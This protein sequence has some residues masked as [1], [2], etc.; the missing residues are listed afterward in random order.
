M[1]P[2]PVSATLSAASPA[3]VGHLT[4]RRGKVLASAGD[5]FWVIFLIGATAPTQL[6]PF[7]SPSR[8]FWLAAYLSVFAMAVGK[9]AKLLAEVRRNWL[10][11]TWPLIASASAL[12]SLAPAVSLYHGVQLAMT[13]LIGLYLQSIKGLA[14]VLRLLFIALLISLLASFALLVI[15]PVSANGWTKE[16]RGIYHHKNEMGLHTLVLLTT[17]FCLFLDGW[18]RTLTLAGGVLALAALAMTKSGAAL[19]T[20][21]VVLTILPLALCH[22]LGRDFLKLGLGLLLLTA[23][24]FA[25]L[26]ITLSL[27]PFDLALGSVGKDPTLTGRTILWQFAWDAIG[28]S[29]LLGLGFKGYWEGTGTTVL[30]LRYVIGQDLWFFHNCFLEVA[31]AFGIFGLLLFVGTLSISAY[32]AASRFYTERSGTTLWSMIMMVVLIIYCFVENPLFWNHSLL[33]LLFAIIWAASLPTRVPLPS[34]RH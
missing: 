3:F 17:A 5:A 32:R 18:K 1:P 24:F 13:M 6:L 23:A 29:P 28:S 8:P 31:V 21:A 2:S 26:L 4:G 30:Y 27:N 33:Q 12:W 22:R 11:M 19:S 9:P 7:E 15:D 20:T 34:A 25:T 16:F 14:S 10:L